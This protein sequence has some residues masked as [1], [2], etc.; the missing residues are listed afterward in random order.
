MQL[1]DFSLE[2]Q[3]LQAYKDLH[4]LLD[5]DQPIRN[6]AGKATG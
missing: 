2:D 1:S 6:Q 4:E 5:I 3:E